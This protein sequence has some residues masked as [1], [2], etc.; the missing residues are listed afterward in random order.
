MWAAFTSVIAAGSQIDPVLRAP[1][2]ASLQKGKLV[3]H[4][5]GS[6][7]V[8][9]R[10]RQ[11]LAILGKTRLRGRVSVLLKQREIE[12]LVVYTS[13]NDFIL[14]LGTQQQTSRPK[15]PRWRDLS[16]WMRVQLG[17]MTISEFQG[18]AFTVH[19]E[20]NLLRAI[21][22]RTDRADYIRRRFTN[23]LGKVFD[24]APAYYLV[25]ELHDS[26]GKPVHPHIHGGIEIEGVAE[27]YVRHAI[28]RAAGHD[29][30]RGP[31]K[32]NAYLGE[33]PYGRVEKWGKYVCKGLRRKAPLGW[34]KRHSMSNQLNGAARDFWE[35]ISETATTEI[36]RRK[37]GAK[38][39]A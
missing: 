8:E 10:D 38:I 7:P 5:M 39:V 4:K 12:P 20:D 3:H 18:W 25:T 23:E 11:L 15:V 2:L 29:M 19:F 21:E 13:L 17:H 34:E 30:D 9:Q 26:H 35:F 32:H 22:A 33:K 31:G 27:A 37:G 36:D 24:V 16:P 1:R 28:R 14:K 6:W